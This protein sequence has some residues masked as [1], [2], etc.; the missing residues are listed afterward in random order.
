[1]G[2]CVRRWILVIVL[3]PSWTFPLSAFQ[4]TQKR[5]PGIFNRAFGGVQGRVLPS[6]GETGLPEEI[7]VTLTHKQNRQIQLNRSVT[8]TGDFEFDLLQP[9]PYSVVVTSPGYAP[10]SQ[11]VWIVGSSRGESVSISINLGKNLTDEGPLPPK[12][13]PKTVSARSLAVPQAAREELQKADAQGDAG[14]TE[15]AIKHLEKALE[16]YPDIPLAYTNL[17]LHYLH[18][19]RPDDAIRCL[20]KAIQQDSEDALAHGNLGMIRLKQGN[21]TQA[22][23]HLTK[24]WQLQ[25]ERFEIL[26]LLGGCYDEMGDHLRALAF[27]RKAHEQNPKDPDLVIQ[28]ANCYILLEERERALQLLE[29]F[30]RTAPNDG[31]VDRVKTTIARLQGQIP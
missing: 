2:W 13:G 16:I 27:Y 1:M 21:L 15:E 31:R 24:S 14:N 17:A 23:E 12:T 6:A 22:L 4:E 3:L 18:L 26:A 19:Q 29:E 25:P 8:S 28:M 10:I 30:I 11:S 20:E 7:L 5:P 9:G